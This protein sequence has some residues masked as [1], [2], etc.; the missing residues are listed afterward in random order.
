MWDP[1]YLRSSLATV[2][3]PTFAKSL[4]RKLQDPAIQCSVNSRTACFSVTIPLQRC[5]CTAGLHRTSCIVHIHDEAKSSRSLPLQTWRNKIPHACIKPL[6]LFLTLLFLI[7]CLPVVYCG[8]EFPRSTVNQ[9]ISLTQI[10]LTGCSC[11]P[12]RG[13]M[14]F[15][16]QP[17]DIILGCF[18]TWSPPK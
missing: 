17:Q 10:E 15:A 3:V 2:P 14:H 11:S 12:V 9:S 8:E 5:R 1:G 6:L 13:Q 7:R 4:K 18:S 16:F